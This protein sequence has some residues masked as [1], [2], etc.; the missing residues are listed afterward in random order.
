MTRR[1][2]LRTIAPSFGTSL[3][4]GQLLTLMVSSL[5]TAQTVIEIRPGPADVAAAGIKLVATT[6]LE[7][8]ATLQTILSDDAPLMAPLLPYG[9]LV[10]NGSP[11]KLRAISVNFQWKDAEG[12]PKGRSLTLTA[13]TQPEDP[14]ELAPEGVLLFTPVQVANQYIGVPAANRQTFLQQARFSNANT[15]V[16]QVSSAALPAILQQEASALA[17]MTDFRAFVEGV[18]FHDFSY[19]GSDNLL[20]ILQ[21]GRPEIHR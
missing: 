15:T 3:L 7:H 16:T 4:Q 19:V 20:T 14:L 10:V 5:M 18:V 1:Q 2:L 13:M 17:D 8:T 9:V 12:L 11:N 6:A 21:R